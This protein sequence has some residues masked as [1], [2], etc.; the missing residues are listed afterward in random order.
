MC[1]LFDIFLHWT[2]HVG[3]SRSELILS[4]L[5]AWLFLGEILVEDPVGIQN[6]HESGVWFSTGSA[7]WELDTGFV[8]HL[9]LPPNDWLLAQLRP[10]NCSCCK[11][12]EQQNCAVLGWVTSSALVGCILPVHAHRGCLLLSLF[13]RHFHR[14]GLNHRLIT[15]ES[16]SHLETARAS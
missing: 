12:A 9:L 2:H 4:V 13:Y 7:E 6:E 5:H 3:T 10:S 16:E 11:T 8:Y 14:K 1:F 15:F